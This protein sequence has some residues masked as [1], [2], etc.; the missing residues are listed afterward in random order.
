MLNL[1]GLCCR[2]WG[3]WTVLVGATGAVG[4][5]ERRLGSQRALRWLLEGG[6]ELQE[7]T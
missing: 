1:A 2:Y 3:P 6:V 7:L 4:T 5:W